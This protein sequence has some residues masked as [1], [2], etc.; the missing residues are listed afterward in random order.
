MS[1]TPKMTFGVSSDNGATAIVTLSGELDMANIEKLEEGV[2]PV[3]DAKPARLVVEVSN[4]RFADSSAIALW[5]R[6]AASVDQFEL[7]G[8]SPLLRRIITS[9]G[10]DTTFQMEP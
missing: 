6:W 3:V 4:L 10:L 8:A 5:V 9:M 7:H 1:D 2:A